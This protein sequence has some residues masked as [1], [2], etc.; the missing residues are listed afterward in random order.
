M[1]R[2]LV[3]GVYLADRETAAALVSYDMA[4]SRAHEVVC[5]WIA[6]APDG[7]GRTDLPD[8]VRVVTAPAPRCDLVNSLLQDCAGF[9]WVVLC[10]DDVELGPDF[11][12]S[13]LA[14]AERHDLALC[15][16]ARTPDSFIDH[17]FVARMPGI[18]ARRTRFVE[19][20]PVVF[21]RRDAAALLLPFAPGSGMGWGLDFVW[22]VRIEAAGLRMGIVDAVPVA[23]R[24]RPPVAGYSYEH[25]MR[26]MSANLSR[27][28]HLGRDEAF[29]ILEAWS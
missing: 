18:D 27:D 1:A 29:T 28:R 9:D 11:L 19:I 17:D 10:D 7:R 23:H 14:L 22:P 15:Q 20:G 25:A 4:G 26:E 8:T 5:R 12:D 2:V 13:F 3:V 24:L 6:L 21:F 16:P